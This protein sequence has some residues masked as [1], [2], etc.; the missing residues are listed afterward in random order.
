MED[1]A[2]DSGRVRAWLIG[3]S[4]GAVVLAAMLISFE[5]GSNQND[6]QTVVERP[7]PAEEVAPPP[8]PAE[9]PGKDLFVTSCGSC[10]TLSDAGSAGVAG[11]N[12]DD[13][14]PDSAQ[15]LSAIELGGAGSGAMPAGLLT[16]DDAVAVSD[17]V[18]SVAGG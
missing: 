16:G 7:A 11:P 14:M 10:H 12:L 15:V 6:E 5:I 2:E 9:G 4:V 1:P 3:V 13:L 8:Q 17:Y 18:A